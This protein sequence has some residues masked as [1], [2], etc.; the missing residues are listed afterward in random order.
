MPL[1]IFS[2]PGDLVIGAGAVKLLANEK[3]VDSANAGVNSGATF[4]LTGDGNALISADAGLNGDPASTVALE[5]SGTLTANGAGAYAA[6]IT[7]TGTFDSQGPGVQ[8]L[9]GTIASTV[10]V[11]VTGGNTLFKTSQ[12]QNQRLACGL[13]RRRNRFS[14]R[15]LQP[16]RRGH[17][18]YL[19]GVKCFKGRSLLS[20]AISKWALSKG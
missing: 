9:S 2:I 17:H 7:G 4:N 20:R 19:C 16:E 8:V 14:W 18:P 5:G 12:V 13:R 15:R 10:G 6:S 11:V 1:P 3:I